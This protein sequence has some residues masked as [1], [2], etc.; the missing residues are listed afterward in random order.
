MSKDIMF[1]DTIQEEALLYGKTGWAI[2]NG[3]NNG[4]FVGFLEFMNETFY[5]AT[6]INPKQEFDMDL[7]PKIRSQI[8]MAAFDS[9]DV[10]S[11]FKK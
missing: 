1:I 11:N 10:Y 4:W 6:N 8:T 3:N 2:R 9:L 7:F 5:F